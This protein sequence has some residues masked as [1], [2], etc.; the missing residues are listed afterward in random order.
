MRPVTAILIAVSLIAVGGA[1]MVAKKA[2]ESRA[3]AA[4]A[5]MAEKQRD[6]EVLVAA[7][8]LEQ[9]HL[10]R[11][12]DMK[13]VVWSV[14]TAEQ[15]KVIVRLGGQEPLRHLNGTALKR[16][17]V[18]G[19]PMSDTMV[20]K[21]GQGSMMTGL[22]APGKR[23]VGLHVTAAASASGFVLPGDRVDV[24]LTVDLSRNDVGET[25]SKARY[26]S[27]TVLTDVRVLAV[28]QDMGGAKGAT[29]ATAAKK[30]KKKSDKE[31]TEG[32][33]PP[34]DVAMVGKTVAIEVSQEEGER[35]MT[36]QQMGKLTLALRSLADGTE[37]IQ[38][39]VPYVTDTDLSKALK[40]LH[41]GGDGV[42]IIRAG[43]K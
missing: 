40:G 6:V 8:N 37:D 9:G 23:A 5:A 26:A 12:E 21:P 28:D 32:E 39:S 35:L 31:N 38:R 19:E 18:A 1:G 33:A 25:A 3:R 41:T 29:K 27:E 15:A 17:V 7:R 34:E 43:A 2:V 10:L 20:F 14:A 11:N 22:L 30:K 4:A 24:I 16:N 36:A 42:K 13:W